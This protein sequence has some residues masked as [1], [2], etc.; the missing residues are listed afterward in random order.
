MGEGKEEEP[1]ITRLKNTLGVGMVDFSSFA[2]CLQQ[3]KAQ[4]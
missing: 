1:E 4:W 2:W 3:K